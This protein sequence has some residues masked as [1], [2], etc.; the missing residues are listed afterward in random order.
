MYTTPDSYTSVTHADG[1]YSYQD[2]IVYSTWQQHTGDVI[3]VFLESFSFEDSRISWWSTDLL[4]WYDAVARQGTYFTNMISNGCT[5]DAWHVAALQWAL[6]RQE[7]LGDSGYYGDNISHYTGLAHLFDTAGYRTSFVSTVTLSFLNQKQYLI[8]NW[9]ENIIDADSFSWVTSYGGFKA[10]P[11]EDVYDTILQI[12]SWWEQW[13]QFIAAQTI[14]THLPY[15]TPYGSR[16]ADAR[17]YADDKLYEFYN[18]LLDQWYFDHGILVLVADHRKFDPLS[19]T[20]HQQRWQSAYG[21]I[22]WAVIGSGITAW[23]FSWYIQHTDIYHMLAQR[24]GGWQIATSSLANDP[25]SWQIARDR[26]I[27]YCKFLD[28]QLHISSARGDY[29][30]TDPKLDS[31][32]REF[33]VA[34]LRY[35]GLIS[36]DVRWDT[37]QL[38]QLVWHRWGSVD[39][40][41]TIKGIRSVAQL[42]VTAIEFDVARSKDDV[43]FLTNWHLNN[44]TCDGKNMGKFM[45]HDAQTILDQC[46]TLDNEPIHTVQQAL[47]KMAG[48]F[49]TM[50][51]ELKIDD[52]DTIDHIHKT[53]DTVVQAIVATHTQ[54]TVT[55]ISYNT[56]AIQ[57]L[58]EQYPQ[59]SVSLDSYTSSDVFTIDDMPYQYFL[60]EKSAYTREQVQHA[61]DI[62]KKFVVYTIQTQQE[63]QQAIDYG[64]DMV[65]VSNIPQ[66]QQWLK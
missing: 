24:Y 59:I 5:S 6:P 29:Y 26:A 61:H 38:I 1:A 52:A 57:Y 66:A 16:Y 44:T 58:M 40:Q 65:L 42:W 32:A 50:F 20:Q 13:S 46:Q 43:V 2:D 15:D 39:G 8:D 28:N 34:Q 45:N 4:S 53:V 9:F 7:K 25:I 37:Q 56:A 47:G 60:T 33:A 18:Q 14:S 41:N 21:K 22:V 31:G 10:A 17:R 12:L 3:L 48:L 51:L 64:V 19:D 55:I 35:Q 54:D 63:L 49:T 30:I 62:G 11:D 27:R 36:D 23:P